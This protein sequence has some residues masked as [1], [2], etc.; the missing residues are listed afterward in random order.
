MD[1][2]FQTYSEEK[3]SATERGTLVVFEPSN[4]VFNLEPIA[5]DFSML[6]ERCQ[7]LSYLTKG[8]TFQLASGDKKVSYAAKNGLVDLLKDVVKSPIH[9]S[10]ISHEVSDGASFCEVALQWT[11]ERERAYTFTN[12][13]QHNEGGT[14]L[15]GAR[16]AITRKINQFLDV[17]LTGEM[18]RTGLVY[19][20]SCKVPNPSFAN[21]TKTK[22]NNPELRKLADR[23]V[24]EALE[25]F[26]QTHPNEMKQIEDFLRKEQRAESAAEKARQDVLLRSAE[27]EK[28]TKKK[29]VLAGKLTDCRIH[30]EKSE[31]WLVEGDSAKGSIIKARDGNHIAVF[32][33]RGKGKNAL[34]EDDFSELLKNEEY[35]EISVALGC[36][37]GPRF[38]EK[39]LRYGKIVIASDKDPDGD[40]IACLLLAFFYRV[41][42]E[43]L[44]SGRVYRAHFPLYVVEKG[45]QRFYLYSK[46]E[47]AE[48][49]KTLP[50]NV[51][52]LY[53][54][55]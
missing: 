3:C 22:I 51:N 20:V 25:K 1:G 9:P 4:E 13:L 28:E 6:S 15:T 44:R 46:E 33:M 45:T 50:K 43:L 52:V 12:G 23:A 36:G 54:K 32:P 41:Y 35:K 48:K 31:L 34:K 40:S 7:N 16:T 5:I 8:L 24:A 55:G 19:A 47:L 2:N 49:L 27:I 17:T 37:Y 30:D 53:K 38:N 29:V 21:Q 26:R 42:P 11:K 18:A 10:P 14:S 39:K